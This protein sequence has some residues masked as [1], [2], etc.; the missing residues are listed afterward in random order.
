MNKEI[1]DIES[2]LKDQGKALKDYQTK[3]DSFLTMES[4]NISL[5]KTIRE[6]EE[7]IKNLKL[8]KNE[9][10][11]FRKTLKDGK[12]NTISLLNSGIE[13]NSIQ[14]LIEL[15]R[16]DEV[17]LNEINLQKQNIKKSI[18]KNTQLTQLI[19]DLNIQ[20]RLLNELHFNF[21][22]GHP[23]VK[24][25]THDFIESQDN[26]INYIEIHIQRLQE[27]RYL[28]KEKILHNI[29]MTEKNIQNKLSM[30]K[31]DLRDEEIFLQT[32]PKKNLDIQ[33]LKRKFTLS[34]N[35]YTFLL[36]KKME[37]EISLASTI[38]NTQIIED[39]RE[40]S[41]TTKPTRKII[42]LIGFILGL[43][44][45]L[46]YI[47][48]RVVL[49]SKIRDLATINTLTDI[50]VY[51]SLP[52]KKNQRFFDEAHRAIRTN[53]QFLQDSKKPCTTILISSSVENEGK[54]TI[55]AGLANM[56]SKT[57]KKVLMMDLDLRKPRL[58]QEIDKS[59]ARGMSHYLLSDWELSDSIQKVNQNLD[60]FPAGDVPLN[61]SELLMS[62]KFAQTIK[63]LL[64]Q[65]DYIVFDTPPIGSVIDAN[66]LLQYSDVVLLLVRA[67]VSK[68]KFIEKFNHLKNDR[69]IER[70]GI[71][72]NDLKPN[73]ID[74]HNYGY[75]YTYS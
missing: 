64:E 55:V 11:S 27:N 41:G 18:T 47:F 49:D 61:P 39:A 65:Y 75:G 25:A 72:L 20:E 9:L 71:I 51:G 3:S 46:L 6:K 57:G 38:A 59:N 16:A 8:Q 35:I 21:T 42:I 31:K 13:I 26:I 54:T 48:L 1:K 69:N 33:E 40:S 7:L 23:E 4:N 17:E 30:L 10:K 67:N 63:I 45:A 68:K 24:K 70:L 12:F 43:I 62:E 56:L 34:E 53:L 22:Q 14:S 74:D 5:F 29:V 50:P 73:Q 15:F 66:L 32:L 52:N 60:F 28:T 36:Q 58:Y 44:L 19:N 2:I 37:M